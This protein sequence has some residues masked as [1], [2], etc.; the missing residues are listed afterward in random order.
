MFCDL[1]ISG[2]IGLRPSDNNQ[3]EIFPLVPS[4]IDYFA[5][6][7]VNYHGKLIAIFYDK[8]GKRYN[9]GVGFHVLV[10]GKEKLFSEKLPEKIIVV[11]LK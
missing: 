5:L 2:L 8:T 9:K 7:N 4:D 6:D 11:S 10:D 3:F 1:I